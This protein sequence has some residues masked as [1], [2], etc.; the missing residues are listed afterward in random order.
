MVPGCGWE[1][2]CSCGF[3]MGGWG[4]VACFPLVQFVLDGEEV[5]GELPV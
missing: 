1:G 5:C 2:F 4:L 3:V